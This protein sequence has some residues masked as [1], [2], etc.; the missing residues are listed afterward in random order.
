[1]YQIL[2]IR[3]R[4]IYDPNSDPNLK[5]MPLDSR[6]MSLRNFQGTDFPVSQ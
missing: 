4:S 1:M 2:K 3:I 5:L 6:K